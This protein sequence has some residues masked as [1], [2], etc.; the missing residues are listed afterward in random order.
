MKA[1]RI[2]LAALSFAAA[3]ILAGCDLAPG[4]DVAALPTTQAVV[5]EEA[6]LPVQVD[7]EADGQAVASDRLALTVEQEPFTLS[8]LSALPR[9]QISAAG[10]T[11]EGV[12][13]L[14]LLTAARITDVL[15][16]TLVARDAVTVEVGVP[17][18]TPESILAIASDNS[19]NAVLPEVERSRWLRDVVVID[20]APEA[21]LALRVGEVPFSFQDLRALEFVE[22]KAG[23]KTYQGVRILDLLR[24]AGADGAQTVILTNRRAESVEVPVTEIHDD[25]ILS[26]GKDD[27]LQA[28]LPGLVEGTWLTDIVEIRTTP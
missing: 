1:Y 12:A 16:I 15:T 20:T 10:E 27:S 14:D 26:L 19:L 6:G 2:T 25:D 8:D 22:V 3:L 11:Y 4:Q 13:I 7:V 21:R 5:A 28:I 24:A 18:L 17:S 9:V 23:N